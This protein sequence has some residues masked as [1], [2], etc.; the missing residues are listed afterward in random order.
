MA[1]AGI[2]WQECVVLASGVVDL[3]ALEPFVADCKP[4]SVAIFFQNEKDVDNLKNFP[5]LQGVAVHFPMG[6]YGIPLRS[7]TDLSPLRWER[8]RRG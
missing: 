1:C 4:A 8:K 6:W 7:G 2:P 5:A 3:G